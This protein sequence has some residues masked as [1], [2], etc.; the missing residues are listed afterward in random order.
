M[1]HFSAEVP[2]EFVN[3]SKLS[4]QGELPTKIYRGAFFTS[5]HR[6]EPGL[7]VPG[8]KPIR[9]AISGFIYVVMETR[10]IGQG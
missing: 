4:G 8:A 1:R 5:N 10:R 3:T 9:G 6:E 7:E 2:V